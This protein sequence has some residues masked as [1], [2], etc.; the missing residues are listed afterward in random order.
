MEIRGK[1]DIIKRQNIHG[2]ERNHNMKSAKLLLKDLNYNVIS[3]SV[4]MPE[5]NKF[6][7]AP[8]SGVVIY[9]E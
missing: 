4:D 1:C 8:Q 3:G 5:M 9:T 6:R 7:I 2:E